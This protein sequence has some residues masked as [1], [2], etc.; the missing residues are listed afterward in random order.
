MFLNNIENNSV[1]P[2]DRSGSDSLK[3]S[4]YAGRDI[5]PMWVADMDFRSAE[6]IIQALH[7]R[8]DHG[9]FGYTVSNEETV[10]AIVHWLGARHNWK[11]QPEWIVQCRIPLYR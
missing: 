8:I 1:I 11:V 2:V 3:W 7:D 10:D 9:V 4:K 5:L 6:P